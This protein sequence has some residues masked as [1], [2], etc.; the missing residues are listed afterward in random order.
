MR[1]SK[2][3]NNSKIKTRRNKKNKRKHTLKSYRGGYVGDD[4]VT[5]VG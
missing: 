1:K 2:I 3:Y 4:I 5:F